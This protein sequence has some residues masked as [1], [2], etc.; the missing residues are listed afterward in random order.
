MQ[1]HRIVLTR[2]FDR[3][4]LS[5][6]VEHTP[7]SPPQPLKR[8]RKAP[9]YIKTANTLPAISSNMTHGRQ[10]WPQQWLDPFDGK[11]LECL[12]TSGSLLAGPVCCVRAMVG[13]FEVV[14]EAGR[15]PC[16]ARGVWGDVRA[17]WQHTEAEGMVLDQQIRWGFKIW[18]QSWCKL[19]LF[20]VFCFFGTRT[21]LC[22]WLIDNPVGFISNER[23]SP[24]FHHGFVQNLRDF[25]FFF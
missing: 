18:Y 16:P 9:M 17:Y 6:V 11:T 2:D 21:I 7:P 4:R 14:T 12:F 22:V 1:H 20:S 15:M 13:V 25:F 5:S 3:W 10:R 19:A 24:G 8:S 23:P